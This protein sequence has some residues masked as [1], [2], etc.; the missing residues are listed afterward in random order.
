MS[1]VPALPDVKAYADYWSTLTGVSELQWTRLLGAGEIDRVR[2]ERQDALTAFARTHSPLY[3]ELYREL[4]ADHVAWERF[5]PVT[6]RTLM[7][8]FDDWV[9]DP[10]VRRGHVDAFVADASRIGELFL[11]RYAAWKSSG[12]T[13]LPGVFLQDRQSLASFDA[14]IAAQVQSPALAAACAMGMVTHGGRAALI[15][16]TG[17]HFASISSWQRLA[18]ASGRA[19]TLELSVLRPL[20]A[21]VD[22]LNAFQPAF[23][24]SYPTVLA[25]L[26]A[27]QAAGRLRISPALAWSGGEHLTETARATLEAG[28]GCAVV[29]EY[30]ASECLSIAFGCRSG[31]LH[32]NADW[33]VLEAVDREYRPV[34]PGQLSDTALLTNLA[35]RVAP[36]VRY[37]IGDRVLV[38]PSPCE[39]GSVLPAIR[40]DGRRDDI[41]S[42]RRSDGAVIDLLPLALSTAVEEAADLHCFQIVQQGDEAL[43]LR[44]P[45]GGR[46][47]RVAAWRAARRA[48]RQLLDHHALPNVDV[49]LDALPPQPEPGSG[50]L[51]QV[52]AR[53]ST[54]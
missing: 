13:G 43:A 39:C 12:S 47:R 2:R 19:S 54:H 5:P 33:V 20:T 22:E 11:E 46:Q 28:L 42:L 25:L 6:K 4:P 36:I 14:L 3:R 50:K 31:W 23:V 26:A 9:T 49:R 44:M 24:A 45:E 10:A 18:R 17:E 41:L 38:R 30:G 35:N 29:N 16:A 34:P 48:L 7:E 52:L 8:R 37:D 15:A 27:E 40:V 53:R 32:V 21:W 51:R 1:I